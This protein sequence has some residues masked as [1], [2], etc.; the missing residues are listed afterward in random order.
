MNIFKK[1]FTLAEV[2]LVM[3]I[4]G[5][6]A[7]LTITNATKDADVAE[8]VAQLRKTDEIL[9]AALAQ[10]VAENGEVNTWGTDGGM[11]SNET[12]GSVLFS[13]LKLKKN[14]TTDT[15]CW[16]TGKAEK[17]STST[18]D[19]N[20]IG[21]NIDNSSSY[22]KGILINGVS[23]AIDY[24]ANTSNTRR[25]LIDANGK[26]KGTYRFGDDIFEFTI[27]NSRS[28]SPI[29]RG[30]NGNTSIESCITNIGVYCT[31]WVYKFGNQDYL[32]PCRNQLSWDDKHT[33]R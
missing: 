20:N 15:G 11:P 6:V 21:D 22:Y 13:Y 5:I 12:V 25:I 33:C 29:E 24:T 1:A 3:G 10:A 17:L 26:D 2:V 4:I 16:T 30:G 28:I 7:T 9:S 14:C 19:T 8:K 23:I 32:K 27:Q 31:S 18:K